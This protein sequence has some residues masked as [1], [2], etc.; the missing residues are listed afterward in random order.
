MSDIH[1]IG[2]FSLKTATHDDWRIVF[3]SKSKV[4]HEATL[5]SEGINEVLR[6]LGE[7]FKVDLIEILFRQPSRLESRIIWPENGRDHELY[8]STGFLQKIQK[9]L[10]LEPSNR[11]SSKARSIL[12]DKKEKRFLSFSLR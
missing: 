3:I 12:G 9:R 2:E 10:S 6:E 7:Y 8:E 4:R 11:L 1:M 5:Y